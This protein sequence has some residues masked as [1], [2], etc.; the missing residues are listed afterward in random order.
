MTEEV[1]ARIAQAGG[2]INDDI[3]QADLL[4]GLTE[5]YCK[6]RHRIKMDRRLAEQRVAEADA[7]VGACRFLMKCAG[8][9]ES[10]YNLSS[11]TMGITFANVF[12]EIICSINSLTAC[13]RGLLAGHQ[14][15]K[16]DDPLDVFRPTEGGA[17]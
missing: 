12:K 14:K 4:A 17:E 13:E 7:L 11:S 3:A 8:K 6:W 16:E 10:N 5:C 15:N 2:R 9:T 1:L